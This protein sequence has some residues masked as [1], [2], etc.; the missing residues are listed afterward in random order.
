MLNLPRWQ[1]IAIILVT[2]LA[3]L[4][5]LPNALPGSVLNY[6]PGVGEV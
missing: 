5:A 4:F 2:A 3:G 1:V 6:L